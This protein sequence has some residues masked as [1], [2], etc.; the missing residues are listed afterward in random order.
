MCMYLALG[1]VVIKGILL[2]VSDKLAVGGTECV[3]T[4]Y[5][6]GVHV[7]IILPYLQGV[8]SSSFKFFSDNGHSAE[9]LPNWLIMSAVTGHAPNRPTPPYP[10]IYWF[11]SR[12]SNAQNA[13]AK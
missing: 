7:T 1:H 13:G 12:I 6:Y 5:R 2:H 3:R 8:P 9:R 11:I 4:K 10:L